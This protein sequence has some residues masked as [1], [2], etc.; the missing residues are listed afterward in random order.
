[1]R[2]FSLKKKKKKKKM[3]I[4]IKSLTVLIYPNIT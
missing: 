2:E 4:L 1:M 3:K